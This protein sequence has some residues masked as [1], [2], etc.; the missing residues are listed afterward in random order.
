[1]P[2]TRTIRQGGSAFHWRLAVLALLPL[3]SSFCT[4][5]GFPPS[6]PG[7]R[8]E[9][10]QTVAV[11]WREQEIR[12]PYKAIGLIIARSD[13]VGDE[14]LMKRVIEKARSVGADAVIMRPQPGHRLDAVAIRFTEE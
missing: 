14:T 13:L 9:P 2:R 11:F 8:Q 12:R 1:M 4:T 7:V 10:R 3:L 6:D 5:I